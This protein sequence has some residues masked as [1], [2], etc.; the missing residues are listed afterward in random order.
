[1]KRCMLPDGDD[2]P[3]GCSRRPSLRLLARVLFPWRWKHELERI[4][5]PCRE[6]V[7]R[8]G[9]R[10]VEAFVERLRLKRVV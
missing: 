8:V 5:T 4:L 9:W 3:I 1:M 6:K 2:M 7:V 10:E